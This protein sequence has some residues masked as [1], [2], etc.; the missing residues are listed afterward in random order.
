MWR[1]AASFFG[2]MLLA[3]ASAYGQTDIASIRAAYLYNFT[4]YIQW[5]DES[6]GELRLCVIGNTPADP[7]IDGLN[8]KP[9]RTARLVVRQNV[10][11]QDIPNCDFV[12]LPT[13]AVRP[14]ERARQLVNGY[15][16]LLVAEGDESIAKGAIIS[17][18]PVD[19]R[20]VFEIDNTGARL[21]GLQIGSQ[22]LRLARKVY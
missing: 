2:L 21:L 22:M 5:P 4:K 8:G 3:M 10:I 7:A 9:V 12:F 1:Q 20:L 18:I 19:N 13:S 6:R 17:L 14:V 15:P 16:I 11:M